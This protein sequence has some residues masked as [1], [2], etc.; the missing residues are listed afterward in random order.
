MKIEPK[1][2]EDQKYCIFT[3]SR[4]VGDLTKTRDFKEFTFSKTQ[5][6]CKGRS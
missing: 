6:I 1:V 3:F 2:W 5:K 4:T